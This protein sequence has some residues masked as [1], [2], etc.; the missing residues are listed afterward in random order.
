MDVPAELLLEEGGQLL[1]LCISGRGFVAGVYIFG[2]LPEHHH[3]HQ[4]RV[5]DRGRD[6]LEVFYRAQAHIEVKLLPEC[7]VQA[8]PAAPHRGGQRPFQPDSVLLECSQGLGRQPV[9]NSVESLLAGKHLFPFY[10]ALSAV[11]KAHCLVNDRKGCPCYIRSCAIPFN[12]WNNG[13]IRNNELSVL[14]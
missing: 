10:P 1:G 11:G 9:A 8:P 6:S 4:L 12:I 5:L 3:I 2:V 7:H 14:H 13:I